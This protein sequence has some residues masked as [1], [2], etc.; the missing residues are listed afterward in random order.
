MAGNRYEIRFTDD[1]GE[2]NINFSKEETAF[3]F[4][5]EVFLLENSPFS[6]CKIQDEHGIVEIEKT[7]EGESG[8]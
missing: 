1:K 7:Q 3:Y 8:K 6:V 2:Q 4:P 5:Q